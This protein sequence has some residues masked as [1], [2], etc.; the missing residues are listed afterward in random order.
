MNEALNRGVLS[1]SH[2]AQEH[3]SYFSVAQKNRN[4]T[5]EL[6]VLSPA[7]VDPSIGSKSSSY[8]RV[9]LAPRS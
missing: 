4:I 1:A 6:A 2:G 3:S 7:A 9:T 8:S 5:H